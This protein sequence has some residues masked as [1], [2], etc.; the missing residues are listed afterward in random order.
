MRWRSWLQRRRWER[1]MDAELQFHLDNQISDYMKQGLTQKDAE[2]RAR[3]EFGPPDLAKDECRDQK[4][5][6]L[7][8][9]FLRDVRYASRSLR[10][11]PG[12]ATAV[13]LTLA[14]GIGAN[15]AIFSVLQGVALS[16]LPY[17]EPDRLVLVALY[18]RTLGYA[19]NLSYPD[20]L[21]WQRNSHSFEQIAAFKG[22]SF[23]LSS[24]GAP[25]H[26]DG[27][28]VSSNFFG[29]LGVKLGLGRDSNAGRKIALNGVAYGRY[30][31]SFVARPFC[32]QPGDAR[33][34]HHFGRRRL[35]HRWRSPSRLWFWKPA[36]GCLH[37]P[38][39]HRP[40]AYAMI[41]DDPRH[42]SCVAPPGAK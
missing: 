12:F 28:E 4:P 15:T 23:D 18:N 41:A 10:K 39:A 16:P 22:Q 19:T 8:D 14:L 37:N 42:N 1:R 20:F 29:T 3:R 33:Q 40:T 9:Q 32:G 2:L 5:L 31:Q 13:V 6:E 38:R 25:E 26:I 34:D 30:Q 11:S 24:P 27:K 21:D 36:G 35:Y 7:L 17:H